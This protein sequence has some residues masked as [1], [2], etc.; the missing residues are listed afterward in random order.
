MLYEK[1]KLLL[2][3]TIRFNNFYRILLAKLANTP[4]FVKLLIKS[5]Q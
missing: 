4:N 3:Y 1:L 5:T 2:N